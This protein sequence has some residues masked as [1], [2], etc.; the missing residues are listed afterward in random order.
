MHAVGTLVEEA[1]D[2]D[3]DEDVGMGIGSEKV[4]LDEKTV[5]P[6]APASIAAG[7]GYEHGRF[8]LVS[9]M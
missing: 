2:E 8:S 7:Y 3:E 1:L 5:M 9:R 4:A 6:D